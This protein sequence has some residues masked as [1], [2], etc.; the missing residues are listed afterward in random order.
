MLLY[1]FSKR[2]ELKK[3]TNHKIRSLGKEKTKKLEC[4]CQK[5]NK[6]KNKEKK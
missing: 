1:F 2:R 4:G 6:N 5:E 3:K